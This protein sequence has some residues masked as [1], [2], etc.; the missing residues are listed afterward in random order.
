M[1]NPVE[2]IIGDLR[3]NR[4][5]RV[6]LTPNRTVQETKALL[7]GLMRPA[8]YNDNKGTGEVAHYHG[9]GGSDCTRWEVTVDIRAGE[10]LEAAGAR[11]NEFLAQTFPTATVTTPTLCSEF[12]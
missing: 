5:W 12:D 3:V 4:R 1:A 9:L 10:T 7:T 2:Q 11:I 8:W 6:E